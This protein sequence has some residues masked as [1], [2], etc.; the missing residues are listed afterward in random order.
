MRLGHA[1]EGAAAA[2][3][4]MGVAGWARVRALWARGVVCTLCTGGFHTSI[5]STGEDAGG[6]GRCRGLAEAGRC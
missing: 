6:V 4:E 3:V 1:P 2:A 5:V